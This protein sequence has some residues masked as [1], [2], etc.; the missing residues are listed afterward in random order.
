MAPAKSTPQIDARI[1]QRLQR[2]IG[3]A[4]HPALFFLTDTYT[5]KPTACFQKA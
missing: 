3:P 1:K 5:R 2:Q 4:S